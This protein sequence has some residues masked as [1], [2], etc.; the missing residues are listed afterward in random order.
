MSFKYE[1]FG[2]RPRIRIWTL[3]NYYIYQGGDGSEH[4]DDLFGP[5]YVGSSSFSGDTASAASSPAYIAP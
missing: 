2:L 1:V 4:E 5:V 3:A